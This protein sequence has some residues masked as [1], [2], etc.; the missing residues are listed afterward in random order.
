MHWYSL[1]VNFAG[2]QRA[3][4]CAVVFR[5]SSIGLVISSDYP[6]ESDGLCFYRRWF[7]CLSVCLS[8][9]TITK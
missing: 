4:N 8:V 6:R 9:T 1:L 5:N 2:V 7:V 3:A